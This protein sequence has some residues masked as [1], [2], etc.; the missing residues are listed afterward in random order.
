MSTESW[1]HIA[2]RMT[3]DEKGLF[4]VR[5]ADLFRGYRRARGSPTFGSAIMG[6]GIFC[7]C[8]MVVG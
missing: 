6:A 3:E 5:Q 8:Q 4:I 1:P 2:A 7:G